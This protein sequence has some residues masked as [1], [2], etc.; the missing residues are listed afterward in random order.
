MSDV[1]RDEQ[2]YSSLSELGHCSEQD[3]SLLGDSFGLPAA[4]ELSSESASEL[5]DWS[6]GE[7]AERRSPSFSRVQSSSVSASRCRKVRFSTIFAAT[8]RMHSSDANTIIKLGI[9]SPK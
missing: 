4:V 1:D 9:S 8:I 2:E 7:L 5:A 3:R 6:A